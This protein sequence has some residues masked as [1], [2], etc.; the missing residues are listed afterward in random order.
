MQNRNPLPTR[1]AIRSEVACDGPLLSKWTCTNRAG[2]PEVAEVPTARVC[3]SLAPTTFSIPGTAWW[4]RLELAARRTTGFRGTSAFMFGGAQHSV[5]AKH[6]N[7]EFIPP[8]SRMKVYV[9]RPRKPPPLPAYTHR[10]TGPGCKVLLVQQRLLGERARSGP[11][12]RRFPFISGS[13][14]MR[15][16]SSAFP[17]SPFSPSGQ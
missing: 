14:S 3:R 17:V 6:A 7:T 13:F 15:S 12:G 1:Y 16:S 2:A 4:R 9:Q 10:A 5:Q 8:S 11:P